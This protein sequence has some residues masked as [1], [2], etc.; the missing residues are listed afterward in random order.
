MVT[1]TF[2]VMSIIS[3]INL[4]EN[5]VRQTK[6]DKLFRP[7]APIY[8]LQRLQSSTVLPDIKQLLSD[9]E[10]T[11]SSQNNNY[12]RTFCIRVTV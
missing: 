5:Y 3:V 9:I 4:L 11:R 6:G 12:K 2:L 1:F 8:S 10:K 7:G